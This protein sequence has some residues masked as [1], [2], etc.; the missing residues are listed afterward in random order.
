MFKTAK[1]IHDLYGAWATNG[2]F[3]YLS[4]IPLVGK[5]IPEK[6]YGM[7]KIKGIWN[8]ISSAVQ[9]QDR[10]VHAQGNVLYLGENL[11]SY[12]DRKSVV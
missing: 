11:G 7:I 1:L 5:F 8:R 6:I 3:Y 4:K 9:P 10:Y 2:F 12:S